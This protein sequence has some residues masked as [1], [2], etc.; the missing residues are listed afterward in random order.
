MKANTSLSLLTLAIFL[1][2]L[3]PLLVQQGM[4]FDGV[5]YAAIAN[6]LSLGLGDLWEPHYTETLYPRFYE[7]PPL[8]FYIQSKFFQLLGHGIHVERIYT[9]LCSLLTS[10]GIIKLF[11][12]FYNRDKQ[13]Q[14]AWLP[15]LIWIT[16]PIVFWSYQ[17]NMLE[18]TL[19]VFTIFSVYFFAKSAEK[20]NYMLAILGAIFIA[21]AFLA[22]GPVG[23]FPLTLP[24]IY[25]LIFQSTLPRSKYLL[26]SSIYIIIPFVLIAALMFSL[27]EA[28]ENISRYFNQQVFAAIQNEREIT[29]AYRFKIIVDLFLDMSLP[30]LLILYIIIRSKFKKGQVSFPHKKQIL[31]FLLIAIS[32]SLPLIISLKQ[33]KFYLIPSIPFFAL[34]A[35]FFLLPYIEKLVR[36]ITKLSLRIINGTT[37][38]IF[39]GTFIYSIISWGEISREQDKIMDVNSISKILDSS[40]TIS[41]THKLCYD[42]S[43]VAYFARKNQISLECNG[44]QRYYITS[45]DLQL[46]EDIKEQYELV[47]IALES[48]QLFKRKN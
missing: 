23:L 19:G 18:N 38:L 31:F 33:R 1:G 43:L 27:P 14:F 26:L 47:P 9:F 8:V 48:Y 15:V 45:N 44:N 42:W 35:A 46:N 11:N 25:Y 28:Y 22:K 32:A 41:A 30:L 12:T 34:S 40:I 13:I 5:T 20:E 21:L 39:V 24:I 37:L 36:T 4:F 10:V 17:N 16:T 29:T 2:L 3:V 7:H 6:N